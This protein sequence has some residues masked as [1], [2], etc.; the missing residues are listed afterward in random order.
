M[1]N[2]GLWLDLLG[3][4][5]GF[6]LGVQQLRENPRYLGLLWLVCMPRNSRFSGFNGSGYNFSIVSEL[7]QFNKCDAM[8]ARRM[9][10]SFYGYQAESEGFIPS[11]TVWP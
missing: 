6:A 1:F 8:R 9:S 10:L 7:N 4:A 5:I 3:R 11:V 2:V